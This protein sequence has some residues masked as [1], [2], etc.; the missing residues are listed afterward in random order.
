MKRSSATRCGVAIFVCVVGWLA[1]PSSRCANH[2]STGAFTRAVYLVRHGAYDTNS[3]V[4]PAVGGSLTPLGIVEARLL[5]NRLRGLPLH[6]D[7]ITSSTMERARETAEI[8]HESLPD[9]GLRQSPDL[10]EC[11]PPAARPLEGASL[12]EQVA[13]AKRLDHVF[14]EDFK[15]ATIAD[16]SDLIVAHGN[17]IRYLVTKA[18]GV[19][20][21]AWPGFSLAHGSLTIIRVRAD[22]TMSV[23]AVGDV[24]HIPANLQSWG[25]TADP[26]LVA[27]K[28]GTLA[29]VD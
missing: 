11:T 5:G 26:Q 23:A 3:K 13:C 27:P 20:T 25:S 21:R 15:P 19:D 14:A 29:P 7:S 24:G 18:L 2:T 10:T 16:R 6:F 1:P 9:V 28:V 22:G 17:V 12:D 8:I 4:D